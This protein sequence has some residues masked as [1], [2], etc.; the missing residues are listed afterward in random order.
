MTRKTVDANF[1]A[2]AIDKLP[3]IDV[4]PHSMYIEGHV[5]TARNVDYIANEAEGGDWE[6][7]FVD[8][9]EALGLGP[10]DEFVVYCLTGEH[11]GLATDLLG[12]YGFDHLDYY[13]GSWL[14]W[15]SD[16][17]RPVES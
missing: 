13:Q 1:V 3:I 15:S 2:A 6:Q 17:D 4:R 14:D 16:P 11:A 12:R 9:V 10:D 5:P 8:K 7:R